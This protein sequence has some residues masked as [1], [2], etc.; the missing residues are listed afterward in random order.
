MVKPYDIKNERNPDFEIDKI[1]LKRWSPRALSKENFTEKDL[2]SL[3]EAA[4]WSPSSSNIQPWRFIYSL[5]GDENWE[6]FFNIL[7]DF[8]QIW[9][10]NS[11]ALVLILSKKTHEK[12]PNPTHSF[13][14]G[15]A[16]M[17]IA[18]QARMKNFIAHAMAGIDY[19]KARDE[20]NIPE[21]YDIEA[22][23]A[24]GSQGEI[25]VLHE[26]MQKSEKPSERKKINEFVFRGKWPDFKNSRT[27]N[28]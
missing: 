6:I 8:N 5:N 24:I 27:N 22:M 28:N 3:F 21:E 17:S 19:K 4:R 7:N 26:R 20:L 16:W 9:A 11:A 23:V 2:F 18:L 14:T 12:K 15:S 10:K 1:F 25:K 13:D